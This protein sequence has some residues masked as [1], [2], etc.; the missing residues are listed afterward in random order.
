[1]TQHSRCGCGAGK[2]PCGCCAGVEALTPLLVTNRPGRNALAYR[3][4]THPTFFE[5]MVARL[6]T[7][8]VGTED[9]CRSGAGLR[10]LLK[11]STR[12]TSD[13]SIAFLDAWAMV[14][15]VLTFYQERIANEGYLR[16]ATER[17]SI[18]ELARLV[19]YRLRPGVSASV[20]LALTIEANEKVLIEPFQVRAQSVPGP[21]ELPQN[22]E[23]VEELEARGVWN[24]LLPRQTRPVTVEKLETTLIENR[25]LK[26]Y[27]KGTTTG[28][29]QG[30]LLLLRAGSQPDAFRI[31]EVNAD[32]A[33]DRTQVV[34]K[35]WLASSSKPASKKDAI[36]NFA[37]EFRNPGAA[38]SQLLAL[39]DRLNAGG[40]EIGRA[41]C[42]ERV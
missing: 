18:L 31:M 3:V 19:G 34:V 21:G 17:R 22:F 4:G 40:S 30:D 39:I 36:K 7:L 2:T 29:K 12:D 6:S 10:P 32:T 15:D 1:M 8:C 28:L 26:L 14:A 27:F 20:H 38:E 16:T 33:A 13:P 11:L 9:E 5:T 25:P 42:R 35:P 23:N 37:T 41:S 24:K